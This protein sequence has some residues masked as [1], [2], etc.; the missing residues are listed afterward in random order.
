MYQFRQ[1]SEKAH[2]VPNVTT[3]HCHIEWYHVVCF[4]S[5]ANL[6]ISNW[7]VYSPFSELH[8]LLIDQLTW[9][10]PI[11]D[12]PSDLSQELVGAIVDSLAECYSCPFLAGWPRTVLTLCWQAGW[13]LRFSILN[14]LAKNYAY[15]KLIGQLRVM[16]LH[17]WLTGQA[18]YFL[19]F[20]LTSWT[21]AEH[22]TNWLASPV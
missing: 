19:Q 6:V 5:S 11:F 15:S 12:G 3:C 22:V 10:F 4:I 8:S 16:V 9:Q 17:T 7:L 21:S 20:I 2:M 1:N 18:L 14:W 13:G